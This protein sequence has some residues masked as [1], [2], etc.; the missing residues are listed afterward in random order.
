MKPMLAA[1]ADLTKL[2]YPMLA[3]PKLDGVRC[4]LK[5]GQV[6]SRSLKPIPNRAVQDLFGQKNFHGIDGELVVGDPTA[7]DVYTKTTSGV[8]SRDGIPEVRL[9]AFD[10][11]SRPDLPY[12]DR[13]QRLMK[14]LVATRA[15][16]IGALEQHWVPDESELLRL[17]DHYLSLGYEGVMLRQPQGSYKHGRSTANEGWLLKLKRFT[18]AEARVVA[19]KELWHNANEAKVNELGYKERSSKKAGKVPMDVL[20]ALVVA[21][22]QTGV[23]FEIGTGFT[24]QQRHD[25]WRVNLLGRLVKYKYQAVG[26]KDKP[27]FPVFAGFRD[28]RDT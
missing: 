12:A 15:R 25:L 16:F 19:V 26:V 21:D 18:D 22:T 28:E 27:R 2:R 23:E 24:E 17:E 10:D 11:F 4:I 7:A 5:D 14:K 13:L 6:L 3:S 8:M 1:K 20:G 9:V